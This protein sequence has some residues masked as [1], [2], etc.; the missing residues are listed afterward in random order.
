[1]RRALSAG[2]A[3]AALAV[4][5]A[6]AAGDGAFRLGVAAGEVTSSSALLWTRADS[7]GPLRVEL[8]RDRHLKKGVTR[9]TVPA[10]ADHDLTVRVRIA[11]L[12]P[13]T[14]YYYRFAARATSPVG[15]FRTAPAP[16]ASATVRFGLTGDADATP[17]PGSTRPFFDTFGVYGRM[18]VEGN[19]FNVNLGDTIY[20]D[21]EVGGAAPA[22]TV[23]QKWAKYRLGLAQPGLR[24]VRAAA[25]L[26]SH[27]DDHEFVNDF[28]RA[29]HGEEI[30][31]AGV[32]AFMDYAPA[33]YSETDGLYRTFRWG[34]NLELFF[35]D[36]RS[37]RSAKASAG[38]T[39]NVPAGVPDLAPTA[40]QPVRDAFAALVP[41]LAQQV[42]A[43]CLATI[44]DPA[45]TL[46]GARQLDRFLAAV[47]RSTATFKVVVNEVPIQQ[48][49]ANPYDRWEGWEP[50]R[51]RVIEH[52]RA[53]AKNVVFLTTDTHA[54]LVGDVRL[55]TL[56]PG[57]PV[58]SGIL[59]VVTGPVATNTF[60]KEIDNIVRS[61]G[62]GTVITA[63]F[64]K[65]P[66]PR[67]IGMQCASTD[68]PS[69]IEVRVTST[70]L[71]IA[72]KDVGGRPVPDVNGVACGPYA[73]SARP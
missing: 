22:L 42:S 70:A 43:A 20:S 41:S 24:Q 27:W 11:G 32:A 25:S 36:E 17:A 35:L 64:L 55:S 50:E 72:P 67:G 37:F 9:K 53:N 71:T 63:A 73:V 21:S 58:N 57:G 68:T 33:S 31:R 44:R 69:Y 26:Y 3:L 52:L 15:R 59:E 61:P 45:R 54:T 66:P 5:G 34:R 30:Y 2:L 6:G 56:E 7:A 1:M 16:G 39:C 8:G 14:L 38:G 12:R 23:E 40:P 29:E 19:D 47:A 48:F 60:A 28:S 46:L 65:P 49:Y 62:S 13:G 51:Q 4:A 18:A 10:R